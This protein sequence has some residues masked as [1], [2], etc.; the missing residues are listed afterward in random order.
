MSI[1]PVQLVL[2]VVDVPPVDVDAAFKT[3]FAIYY[4]DLTVIAEMRLGKKGEHYRHE[5]KYLHLGFSKPSN[6]SLALR[7]TKVVDDESYFYTLSGFSY[8]H[9]DDLP[10]NAVVCENVILYMDVMPRRLKATQY[11]RKFLLSIDEGCYQVVFSKK[12]LVLV[13]DK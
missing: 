10:A 6:H 3:N 12:S 2:A 11:L 4:Y 7:R 9:V 8:Q 5:P 13:K 1:T